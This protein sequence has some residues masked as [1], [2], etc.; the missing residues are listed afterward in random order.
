MTKYACIVDVDESARPR[1]EGAGQQHHQDPITA[2]HNS[3]QSGTQIHSDASIIKK[4]PDA[5]GSS[6]ERME[7]TGENPG[8]T[9]DESQKQE[10]SD[11]R[12]K[13]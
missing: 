8:M 2:F 13:E 9:A 11:R 3:L 10:R 6:G 12:S 7:K 1:L 4:I 5:K